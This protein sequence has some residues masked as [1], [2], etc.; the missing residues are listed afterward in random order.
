L[1]DDHS[2]LRQLLLSEIPTFSVVVIALLL[3]IAYWRRDRYAPLILLATLV[4]VGILGFQRVIHEFVFIMQDHLR[5]P[6]PSG[7]DPYSWIGFVMN[8]ELS[9]IRAS[10]LLL[11]V[12]AA[13]AG[14]RR[15]E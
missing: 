6:R 2:M 4:N 13:F 11:L 1:A 10:G 7:W 9:A 3:A 5:V 12:L 14:R 8:L 15:R